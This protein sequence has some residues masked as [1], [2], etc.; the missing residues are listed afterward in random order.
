MVEE[1]QEQKA[2]QACRHQGADCPPHDALAW[3]SAVVARLPRSRSE[4]DQKGCERQCERRR[5]RTVEI[6]YGA[7]EKDFVGQRNK[8]AGAGEQQDRNE[9]EKRLPRR[10]CLRRIP[11]GD[12]RIMAV[13]PVGDERTCRHRRIDCDRDIDRALHAG[14]RKQY[15]DAG[16]ARRTGAERIHI[17]KERD[18]APDMSAMAGTPDQMC[19]QHRQRRAHQQGRDDHQ[20]QTDRGHSRQRQTDGEFTDAVEDFKREDTEAAG[21]QLDRGQQRQ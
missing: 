12:G 10:R 18:R 8:T 7:E 5:A 11:R 16:Q 6:G 9:A 20:R 21:H 13:A 19:D 2:E 17:I 1:R 15:R 3:Q 14:E 4:P